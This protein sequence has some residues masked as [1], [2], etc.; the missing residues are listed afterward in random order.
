[1][2][3]QIG[4]ALA[5]LLSLASTASLHAQSE[6]QQPPPRTEHKTDS[7]RQSRPQWWKDDKFRAEVGFTLE[8]AAEIDKIFAEWREK[9]VPLRE[10]VTELD[11]KIEKMSAA[12]DTDLAIFTHT[13]EKAEARRAELNKLRT[14]MLYRISRV[15]TPEQNARFHGAYERWQAAHRKQD[16][17]RRK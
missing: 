8:Q 12:R 9:A 7:N 11:K 13:V 4:C 5:I 6:Q 15:F 3:R 17:N 10:Q 16:G 2:A 1:M 14:V